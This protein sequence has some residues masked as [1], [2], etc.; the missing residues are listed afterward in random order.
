MSKKEQK[1]KLGADPLAWIKD[2]ATEP[3]AVTK[4]RRGPVMLPPRHRCL[5]E[6]LTP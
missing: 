5:A 2:T 1:P 6:D 3:P 4:V